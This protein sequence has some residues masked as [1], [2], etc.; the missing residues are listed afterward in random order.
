MIALLKF[1]LISLGITL[2]LVVLA[3]IFPFTI[4]AIGIITIVIS[5]LAMF[6]MIVM[7]VAIKMVLGVI[8]K[9]LELVV[10]VIIKPIKV[11]RKAFSS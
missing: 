9:L 3:I 6:G 5:M 7:W 1:L 11:M 4:P 8:G 10:G 2:A